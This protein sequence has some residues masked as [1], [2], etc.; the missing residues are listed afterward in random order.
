M[1]IPSSA[2]LFATICVVA[3]APAQTFIPAGSAR[4]PVELNSRANYPLM[5]GGSRAQFVIAAAEIQ[6]PARN[7]TRLELRYDGPSFGTGGGT[8]AAFELHLANGAVDPGR[9]SGYFAGNHSGP[10]TRVATVLNLAFP[11]DTSPNPSDWGSG[12]ALAFPFQTPFAYAG[13][14]LVVELRAAGNSNGGASPQNCQL[15]AEED[16]LV[17]PSGGS[18]SPNGSGCHGAW[19]GAQG[20]LAPGGQIAAYGGGFGPN[21][22]VVN[23]LGVSRTIW[24]GIPLPLSLAGIGAPGCDVLNDWLLDR[25][26]LADAAGNVAPFTPALIWSVPPDPV[27]NGATIQFQILAAKAGAN[28]LGLVTSQNVEV[29]LGVWRALYRGYAAHFHHFDPLAAVASYSAPAVL[30]MR[31]P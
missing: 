26:T 28:Q 24:N 19:L 2:R 27:F 18:T 1:R 3:A 17:G 15:D 4:D 13:G 12:G 21:Q 6:S 31:L 20:Q 7:L 10:L 29:R 5:R 9:S 25:R 16:P 14:N 8:L 23:T 11:A 22:I 30:A